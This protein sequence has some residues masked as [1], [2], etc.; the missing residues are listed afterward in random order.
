MA[1]FTDEPSAEDASPFDLALLAEKPRKL[2]NHDVINGKRITRTGKNK[3][4]MVFDCYRYIRR[5]EATPD[6]RSRT[7][8]EQPSTTLCAKYPCAESHWHR[9]TL[10]LM[11]LRPPIVCASAMLG[12]KKS[13]FRKL[14][15]KVSPGRPKRRSRSGGGGGAA[16]EDESTAS[17]YELA[18]GIAQKIC[19]TI[20]E[21]RAY[22]LRTRKTAFHK[23]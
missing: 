1:V 9:E 20:V 22:L 2:R 16:R 11:T 8:Y 6:G 19:A 7:V 21:D 13:G 5:E 23:K 14:P 4:V 18:A 3:D 15:D 10:E 17:R 12:K